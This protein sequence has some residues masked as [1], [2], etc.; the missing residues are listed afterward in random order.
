MISVG[1]PS[2]SDQRLP[3]FH[4]FHRALFD[5][6]Y[7]KPVRILHFFAFQPQYVIPT[8]CR[9]TDPVVVRSTVHGAKSDVC[10][11]QQPRPGP[12][13][14]SFGFLVRMVR[15]DIRHGVGFAVARSRHINMVRASPIQE[16][17]STLAKS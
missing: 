2:C 9:W 11:E 17:S 8:T 12:L 16:K 5:P 10:M 14:S 7:C 15:F 6:R 1:K 4:P 13:Q 3:K